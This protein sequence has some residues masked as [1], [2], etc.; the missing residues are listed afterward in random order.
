[1]AAIEKAIWGL[2]YNVTQNAAFV[3]GIIDASGERVAWVFQ[4]DADDTVTHLGFRYGARAATP[5]TYRISLQALNTSG[6]PDNTVLGGGTPAS[7]TFTP[8]ADATWDGTW[9]WIA[10]DNSIAV[11]RGGFYAIVV[12]YSSGTIDGTNN[13]SF[14]TGVT[15]NNLPGLPYA[16][17]YNGAAW[18]KSLHAN[19]GYKSA[20]RTYG[21]PVEAA[22]NLQL[23]SGDTPDEWGLKITLPAGYGA[24]YKII[25]IFGYF[26]WGA[27]GLSFDLKLYNSSDTLLQDVTVDGDAAVNA[28]GGLYWYWFNETTL[29]TL[30]YGDTYRVTI[31]PGSTSD[32]YFAYYI[33]A[34]SSAEAEAFPFGNGNMFQWTERADAGAWTDRAER[35]PI[36]GIVVADITEP[37]GGAGIAVLTGGGLV[38]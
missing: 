27:A 1:M 26:R 38:R 10:L 36:F 13:S 14:T 18:T 30:N 21:M 8:P 34:D 29:E 2:P 4:A 11:T 9:Q 25:G 20:S 28:T 6:E 22:T 3:N 37:S 31:V 32:N 12:D 23:N 17:T 19:Y 5:P 33:A 24:T 15:G 16:L 7:A 35:R